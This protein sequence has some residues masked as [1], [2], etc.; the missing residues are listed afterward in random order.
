MSTAPLEHVDPGV[1]GSCTPHRRVRHE[2]RD[3]VAVM[4]FSAATSCALAGLL[5]L[6]VRVGG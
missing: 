1:R 6:V 4:A 5:T 2:L 3:A